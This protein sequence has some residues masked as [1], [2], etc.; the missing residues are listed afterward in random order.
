MSKPHTIAGH[1][2]V[3]RQQR[4]TV[5]DGVDKQADSCER[6]D[7]EVR[8]V[9]GLAKQA[10][11]QHWECDA[12]NDDDYRNRTALGQRLRDDVHENY[13][14]DRQ[15]DKTIKQFACNLVSS[16]GRVDWRAEQQRGNAQKK[17]HSFGVLGLGLK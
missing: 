16:T 15:D 5:D 10:F 7:H 1:P 12:E 13:Y 8:R 3:C 4:E 11:E 14:G 2:A 9:S 6:D 17:G